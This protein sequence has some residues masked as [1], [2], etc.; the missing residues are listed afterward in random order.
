MECS[1]LTALPAPLYHNIAKFAF[2]TVG[3]RSD[4]PSMLPG[5]IA[6]LLYTYTATWL[7]STLLF[8]REAKK[9]A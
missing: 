2:M 5:Y 9:A 3:E 6:A 7:L 1:E 8:A 4:L